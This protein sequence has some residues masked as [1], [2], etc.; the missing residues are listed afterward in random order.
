[1]LADHRDE[2]LTKRPG[3]ILTFD[4]SLQAQQAPA[5]DISRADFVHDRPLSAKKVNE[6]T[7]QFAPDRVLNLGSSPVLVNTRSSGI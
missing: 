4:V 3:S 5:R 1:M 2:L 6:V 7:G